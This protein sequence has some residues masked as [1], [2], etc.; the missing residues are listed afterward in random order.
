SRPAQR[1]VMNFIQTAQ[2]Y[3]TGKSAAPGQQEEI[4]LV[5][6]EGAINSVLSRINN[7][8][9]TRWKAYRTQAESTKIPLFKD[10][11]PIQ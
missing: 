5:Q 7:F 6:A 3:I 10:Y 9:E 1:T 11:K 8:Y 2:G 4:L